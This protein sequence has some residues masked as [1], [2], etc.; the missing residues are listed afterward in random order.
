MLLLYLPAGCY[1]RSHA[2]GNKSLNTPYLDALSQE[3]LLLKK[4][5]A[6]YSLCGP[7]RASLLTGRRPHTTHVWHN[8]DQVRTY[9]HNFTTLP[10]YFKE[11]GYHS[12]GF[13]K[14]YHLDDAASWSEPRYRPPNNKQQEDI[15]ADME[16]I[17]NKYSD[18]EPLPDEYIVTKVIEHFK[19]INESNTTRPFFFAI[20]FYRPHV[21]FICPRKYFVNYPEEAERVYLRDIT[22]QTPSVSPFGHMH[23]DSN[24]TLSDLYLRKLRRAYF[25]CITYVDSLVGRIMDA[26]REFQLADSTIVSFTSDHGHHLGENGK[27]G[28]S[29]NL[30]VSLHV[31]LMIRVP[32]LTDSGVASGSIAELIDVFPT[33]IQ[34]AGLPPI[35][36][37]PP[38]SSRVPLC[39]D[40][41]T[42]L[43]LVGEPERVGKRYALSQLTSHNKESIQYSIRTHGYRYTETFSRPGSRNQQ[44]PELYDL[45]LDRSET[46]NVAMHKEYTNALKSYHDKL[47]TMVKHK[48]PW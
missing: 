28:K 21:P 20:G 35:P 30:D 12:L 19:L 38:K 27:W 8:E 6:Q 16:I 34:A 46:Q 17:E 26:L 1:A 32:G 43:D 5:F 3:S 47:W 15:E 41:S 37:C 10:Q 29:A 44:Q 11:N 33:L 25:A 18:R 4:A 48:L 14:V 9:Q 24:G 40:G 45:K 36:Q 2:F 31:P 42:L 23:G 13:G 22:W 7:S 39:S